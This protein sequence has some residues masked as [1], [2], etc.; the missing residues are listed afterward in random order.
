MRPILFEF[1]GV[2]FASWYVFFGLGGVAAFALALLL[3]HHAETIRRVPG[4]HAA[5]Q[6]FPTLFALCYVAGWLGARAF[7]LV[8][9]QTD[10]DTPAVFLRELASLGPMTFYGGALAAFFAGLAYALARRLPVG[11][12][13]DALFPAASLGL[14]LGRVGC[15]LNGDDFGRAV[16][17]QGEPP[18]W[19][20]TFPSLGDGV[21]RYPVQLEEAAFSFLVAAVAAGVFVRG[22]GGLRPGALAAGVALASA[23]HRFV[24]EFFRGDPRGLFWGTTL[25]TSQGL[26]VL[27]FFSA[28]FALVSLCRQP[29]TT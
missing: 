26:A 2:P 21:A 17:N 20:V 19:A 1:A 27:V 24:N 7:S 14:A 23:A 5:S 13:A 12:L 8:R 11:L 16:A 10:V 28:A 6:A 3:L 18:W 9:E 29:R 15:H 4:A 25:S 22:S